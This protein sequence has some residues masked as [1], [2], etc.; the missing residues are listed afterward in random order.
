MNLR[1]ITGDTKARLEHSVEIRHERTLQKS[2]QE[3]LALKT[4]L[5]DDEYA[6]RLEKEGVTLQAKNQ[7]IKDKEAL[8]AAEQRQSSGRIDLKNRLQ[9]R[10]CVVSFWDESYEFKR[11][12]HTR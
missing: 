1:T 6:L 4:Q 12:K 8:K 5:E 10:K 2:Q 7:R 11:K 3:V 9:R